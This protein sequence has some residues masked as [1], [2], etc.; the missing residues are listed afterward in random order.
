MRE[1]NKN[2]RNELEEKR[3]R[4]KEKKEKEREAGCRPNY[5]LLLN[6][7]LFRSKE[8]LDFFFLAT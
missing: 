6:A 1:V 8:E 2:G 4:E 5:C 7:S 3:K